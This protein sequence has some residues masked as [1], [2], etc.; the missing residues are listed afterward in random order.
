M[1]NSVWE[2]IKREFQ[3]GNTLTRLIIF[4]VAVFVL[5]NKQS[6]CIFLINF[7]ILSVANNQI[8]QG[9]KNT[10]KGKSRQNVGRVAGRAC[11]LCLLKVIL[12]GRS[13]IA[14]ACMQQVSSL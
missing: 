5:V 8:V 11:P 10:T 1:F 4:N 6:Y 7:S 14:V 3:Y 9:R 13:Y 12:I 2:D